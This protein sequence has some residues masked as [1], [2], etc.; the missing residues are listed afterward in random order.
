MVKS[1][2]WAD[3][4]GTM[5]SDLTWSLGPKTKACWATLVQSVTV[6]WVVLQRLHHFDQDGYWWEGIWVQMLP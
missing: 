4:A 3:W 6:A 2:D 5:G 1:T